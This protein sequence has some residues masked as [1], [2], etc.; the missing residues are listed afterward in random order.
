VTRADS[1]RP[2]RLITE[3]HLRSLPQW[4]EQVEHRHTWLQWEDLTAKPGE[5]FLP[6][7]LA[8]CRELS[9]EASDDT[10]HV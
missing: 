10:N 4:R 6:T 5:R 3:H 9:R 2:L 1:D 7:D 8:A